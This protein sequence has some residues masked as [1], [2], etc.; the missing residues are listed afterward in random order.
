MNC[1]YPI[2]LSVTRQIG[3]LWRAEKVAAATGCPIA[4]EQAVPSQFLPQG[5]TD[6]GEEPGEAVS[7]LAEAGPE[8]Q[9]QIDEQGRPHLPAHGV[10]VVAEEV[11][12]LQGLFEFLEK[13]LDAPAAAV[14][15]GD[16]LRAPDHIVGQK[17]HFPEFAVHLDQGGNAAQFDRIKLFGRA[18]QGDQVVA[19]NVS[20]RASLKF[21]D[22][23]ALQIVLGARDPE[24]LAHGQVSEMGE[25][26][27]RLVKDDNLP[28][29]YAR[30]H[31][32]RPQVVMFPSGGHQREL[33]QERLQIQPHMAFGGRLTPAMF[34][35]VQTPGDQL[36]GGRVH[37]VNHPLEPEGETRP[38]LCAKV[39][40]QRLQVRQHFPEQLF[41]QAGIPLPV[42]MG[43]PVLARRCGPA[44]RR[45]R[46]GAQPQGIANVIEAQTVRH[47]GI[48]QTDHM[49]P[50]TERAGL[51][52]TSRGPCQLRHQMVGNQIAKLPQ[53]RKLTGGWLVSCLII[54]AL[55]CG[56]AQTRKPTLFY[57]STL[58]LVGLLCQ[59]YNNH[60]LDELTSTTWQTFSDFGSLAWNANFN[61]SP[62]PAPEPGTLAL[63]GLGGFGLLWQFR[64]RK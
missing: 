49:T 40:G 30:T 20:V 22:D 1:G 31:F 37:D 62:E 32:P 26:Q 12:Q 7:P 47:L 45:Q 24:H 48:K 5:R 25:V 6:Q 17:N 8:A 44:N 35:P 51:G 9:Q 59:F 11:G 52:F 36:D 50:R 64:R 38:V 43:K 46:P 58:K 39:R 63:A 21:A 55:P 16:G 14:E 28:G 53:K 2:G 29:L 4:F 18:G 34:G 10:G 19:Q 27:I 3:L 54:H 57:P 15:I 23:A 60:T 13:Y 56:R 42:G 41:G 61:Y 33:G